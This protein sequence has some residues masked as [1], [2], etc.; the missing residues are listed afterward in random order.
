MANLSLSS[1]GWGSSGRAMPKLWKGTE[2]SKP[3][4]LLAEMLQPTLLQKGDG[5]GLKG[6]PIKLE[7]DKNG[8]LCFSHHTSK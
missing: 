2:K 4:V 7:G 6:Y 1:M 8:W 3:S 5:N